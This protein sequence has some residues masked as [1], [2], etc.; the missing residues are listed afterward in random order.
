MTNSPIV[1]VSIGTGSRHQRRQL[2][3]DSA[4][5][6]DRAD[7]KLVTGR[8]G[9]A[10][11]SAWRASSGLMITGSVVASPNSMS[12]NTCRCPRWQL[13]SQPSSH[14]LTHRSRSGPQEM[15][16][17]RG[18]P[19]T[20]NGTAR[21]MASLRNL[22]IAI[23]RLH[24]WRNIAAARRHNAR[25]PTRPSSTSAS[26]TNEPDIPALCRGPVRA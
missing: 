8:L 4:G 19:Q 18:C 12:R 2:G 1:S 14:R 17:R 13:A 9:R 24:G 20:R 22:A 15:T 5:C 10:W 26:P 25:D 7:T 21:A 3:D 16:L 23:L 6:A 11:S